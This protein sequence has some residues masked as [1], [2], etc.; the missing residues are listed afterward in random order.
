[1]DG[2]MAEGSR[3]PET[4]RDAGVPWWAWG[5]IGWPRSLG[6]IRTRDVVVAIMVALTIFGLVNVA[7]KG[8]LEPDQTERHKTD[9]T[10]YTE[11][12]AAFFDGRD[13]YR[14]TNPRGWYYLYPPL[15][16]LLVSPLTVFDTEAQVLA[17]YVVSVA[18]AFGCFVEGRKTWRAL[19]RDL[20]APAP[21]LWISA[22]ALLAILL[23]TFDCFQ[24]G[25]MGVALLYPLLLGYRLAA[26][27]RSAPAWFL[28][29]L[30]LAL[31][32]AIKLV[33]LL[34]VGFV[35]LQLAASAIGPGRGQRT[36]THLTTVT[37]GVV[38][39][40]LLYLFVIPAAC[41]GWR[42]NVE[43]L[44]TWV[45]RVAAN[46]RV[47]RAARFDIHSLRNQSLPNA[48]HLLTRTL[49]GLPAADWSTNIQRE[50]AD[51]VAA[52]VVVVIRGLMVASLLALGLTSGLRGDGLDRATAFGLACCATLPLS[53][54]TWGHYYMIEL[55]AL[56]FAPLWLWRRGLSRIALAVA[57]LPALL[58]WA[59]YL[60][61]HQV[62]PIGLLGLGTTLWIFA[63]GSLM[64][65][66]T[67]V[68][69]PRFAVGPRFARSTG[70]QSRDCEPVKK[71]T[72][73]IAPGFPLS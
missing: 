43:S 44:Q 23:P 17:W 4:D 55:P 32:A 20:P 14:V 2:E 7:P 39:G 73:Q 34:P 69:A 58:V 52:W 18:L 64:A 29:G 16:A 42:K 70:R 30:M 36:T 59:H 57:T 45:V 8:R 33:P 46:E 10:V 28:G 35:V 68:T 72:A 53:P 11:A 27:G 15:F 47:G 41:I 9:F 51:P 31:P 48:V 66:S 65:A 21:T 56:L 12:G 49:R 37:A 50:C 6:E 13:P 26:Q 24:R 25:Q 19:A 62:G 61:I 54:L 3:P 38:V 63:I 1:M 71:E 67:L 22:C 60:F 40:G 5:G